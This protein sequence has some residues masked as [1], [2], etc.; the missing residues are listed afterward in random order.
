MFTIVF[1]SKHMKNK[2]IKSGIVLSI[3]TLDIFLLTCKALDKAAFMKFPGVKR[4]RKYI[5]YWNIRTNV[6]SFWKRWNW[7]KY[8]GS[9]PHW[10]QYVNFY[11]M[12]WILC[13]T[14]EQQVALQFHVFTVWVK[15]AMLLWGH[16]DIPFWMVCI[17]IALYWVH[18][19]K[20]R[21]SAV[22]LKCKRWTQCLWCALLK[23]QLK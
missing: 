23:E 4:L 13:P 15:T 17:H 2:A 3:K 8:K 14:L 10:L 6:T 18:W 12:N 1:T 9:W 22:N 16:D 7:E 20:K 21:V 5:S 19:K 11:Y